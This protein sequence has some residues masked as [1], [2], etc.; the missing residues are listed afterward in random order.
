M[1]VI[2]GGVQKLIRLWAPILAVLLLANGIVTTAVLIKA[3]QIL[4]ALQP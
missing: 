4:R 3:V 1:N 2:T